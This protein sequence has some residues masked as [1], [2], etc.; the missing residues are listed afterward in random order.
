VR[1][2]AEIMEGLCVPD[3]PVLLA[4]DFNDW[5]RKLDRV[6]VGEL[7]FHN[8]FAGRHAHAVK[9]WHSKRPVFSLDRI[10]VRHLKPKRA[11]RLSGE[12]WS[13]LSDHLPLWAELAVT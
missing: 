8:A 10:Y 13:L 7:G 12:P 2:L 4:G 9:T 3:E 6:I 11:E 1:Q 5:H